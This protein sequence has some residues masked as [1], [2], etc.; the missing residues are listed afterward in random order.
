MQETRQYILDILREK[1]QATVDEMVGDLQKRR[2]SAITA[3]TVRH[4]LNELLKEELITTTDLKHRDT[5]G[6]PQHV[7][8]LTT[9][10]I[11]HFPN[12]YQPLVNHLLEQ[13]SNSFPGNEINVV[14]EGI[15]DSMAANAAIPA[16]SVSERLNYVVQYLNDH[17]YNAHWENNGHG[18]TLHTTNCPYHQVAKDNRIL[19]E[20]DMRLVSSLLGVVPRLISRI[21]DGDASCSYFIPDN[22]SART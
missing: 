13:L 3:V 4:H 21:S 20:M 17:G 16:L 14:F 11:S 19:C 8:I 5:P 9:A 7:Y 18:F 2:G 22:S 6:R 12:N 15:A 10:A 1:G